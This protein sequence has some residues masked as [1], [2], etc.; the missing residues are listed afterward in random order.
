MP[1]L[2]LSLTSSE[3]KAALIELLFEDLGALSVTLIDAKDQPLLEP[4]PGETPL[5]RHTRVTALFQEDAEIAKLEEALRAHVDAATFATLEQERIEDQDW[6]RAWMD[7]FR[8]MHYGHHLWVCPAGQRPDDPQALIVELDPGLAF[9]SGTHPTT[10]LCLEWLAAHDLKDQTLI[11]YGCGSGILGIVALRLGA[12]QVIAVDHDPQALEATDANARKNAVQERLQ[13]FSPGD[14]P[15]VQSDLLVANILAGILEELEPTLAERV[16]PQGTVLLSGILTEQ[17]NE[18]IEA[19]RPH[20]TMQPPI[21][22]EG[23]VRLEGIR[24]R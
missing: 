20:F 15:E 2:Q 5:W 12:K 17:A 6:E 22:K 18:V 21:E 4:G 24:T 9:G 23:W 1:W 16:R 10:A 14:M 13:I 19:Y 3:E 8:P 11:D 7:A